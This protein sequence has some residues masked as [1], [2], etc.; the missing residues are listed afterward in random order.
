[1]NFELL[2]NIGDF[3]SGVAVVVSVIY[4]ALQIRHNTREVVSASTQAL[5]GKSVDIFTHATSSPMPIVLS[6]LAAGEE[7]NPEEQE[8]F[9][10]FIRRN[11]QL[12]ELV[13]LQYR[14]GR[15][16]EE[17]MSAYEAR[18][19]THLDNPRWNKEWEKVAPLSTA[20]FLNYVQS[21]E[22]A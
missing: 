11:M 5:L 12:F 22:G 8:R 13:Y 6:K 16:S 1:M 2:G 10:V 19:R 7:L 3:V 20:S 17:V 4:L 15:V 21:L 9:S 14:E 18:I